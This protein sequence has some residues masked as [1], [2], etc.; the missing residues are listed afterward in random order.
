MNRHKNKKFQIPIKQI[1]KYQG[2]CN[3]ELEACSLVDKDPELVCLATRD[4][5]LFLSCV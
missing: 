4:S 2:V 3:M 1:P 5:L